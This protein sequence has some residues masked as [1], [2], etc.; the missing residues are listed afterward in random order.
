MAFKGVEKK[1][2]TVEIAKQKLTAMAMDIRNLYMNDS[3]PEDAVATMAQ[4]ILDADDFESMFAESS[5]EPAESLFDKGLH[6]THINFNE[7]D[8]AEGIPFY[9][10][11]HG[12]VLDTGEDFIANCGAWQVTVVAYK[13]L[14]NDWLPRDFMFHRSEKPTK[15]GYYPVN[16]LPWDA[17]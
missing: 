8:Y 3:S 10:T 12:K 11:F 15:R 4:S 14:K 2:E 5:L 6:V 17:F 7:S 16:I 13:C 1:N 9:A